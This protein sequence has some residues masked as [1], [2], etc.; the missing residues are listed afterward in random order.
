VARKSVQRSAAAA[1]KWARWKRKPPRG[2]DGQFLNTH[3]ENLNGDGSLTSKYTDA[4]ERFK[5]V[6]GVVE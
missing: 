4:L 2:L 6:G 1:P 5:K 3:L